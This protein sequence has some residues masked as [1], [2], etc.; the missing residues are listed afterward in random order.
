MIRILCAYALALI[1]APIEKPCAATTFRLTERQHNALQ[2]NGFRARHNAEWESD[3]KISHN[4][5]NSCSATTF[6]ISNNGSN[7]CVFPVT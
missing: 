2:R 1:S 3:P 6:T 7:I 4:A 5:E